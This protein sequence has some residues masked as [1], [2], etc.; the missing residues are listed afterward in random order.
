MEGPEGCGKTSHM[1]HL[2]EELRSYGLKV[3]PTREPGGTE[4]GEQIREIIH[5]LKNT[6]MDP[7]TETLLFQAARAQIVEQV[8]RPLL[9]NGEIVIS[10][11]F[12]DSTI[13][14]QGYGHRQDINK[15]KTLVS[16]ATGGL[17]PD[18]TIF[19]DVNVETGL[20]RKKRQE[21][22]NRMDSYDVEFHHRVY[23]GYMQMMREDPSRWVVV[24]ANQ[25]IDEVYNDLSREIRNK[26]IFNGF[27][28]SDRHGVER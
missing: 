21:E 9:L 3:F 2:V 24:N 11:R 20:E 5:N 1:P 28:E 22:W 13:A 27:L 14:Y 25:G 6:D 7:R 15:I 18:L 4:I 26:L 8:I 12:F 10:D 19:A 23:E 16:Y 17:T